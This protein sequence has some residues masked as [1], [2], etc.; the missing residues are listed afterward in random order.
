MLHI[1]TYILLFFN[2]I[3]QYIL[4]TWKKIM[5]Q[6]HFTKEFSALTLCT[7]L[8]K[9]NNFKYPVKMLFNVSIIFTL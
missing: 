8:L 1:A 2:F 5:P 6:L 9:K 3:Y 4:K 7:V